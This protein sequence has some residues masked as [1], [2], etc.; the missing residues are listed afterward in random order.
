MAQTNTWEEKLEDLQAHLAHYPK[1]AVAFSSG[2]DSTFLLAVAHRVLGEK[3][4]ALTAQSPVFPACEQNEAEDFCTQHNIRHIVFDVDH[5]NVDGFAQNPP[6]RCYICKHALFSQMLAICE[7]AGLGPL[8]DGSNTD[9]LSDF[10]PGHKALQEL[11]IESPLVAC[12]FSKQDIRDASAAMGLATATKQSFACLATRFP[13]GHSITPEALARIDV[14]EQALLDLG[15]S[16]VRVRVNGEEA[17]IE[18][19]VEEFDILLAHR[20]S[21]VAHIKAAGFSYVALDL[22]G[23]RTG[24]MNETLR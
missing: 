12:G 4:C 21:V 7:E 5:F 13:Y 23:Y 14:A 19:L 9:D 22:Q 11:A 1:L 8:V 2:V 20:E 15:L 6:E 16:T 10:R 18:I 17:R 3:V 24:S